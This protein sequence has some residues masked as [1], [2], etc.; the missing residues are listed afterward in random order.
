MPAK[1]FPA[2][3][4]VR[5]RTDESSNESD[6]RRSLSM[7]VLVFVELARQRDRLRFPMAFSMI[8]CA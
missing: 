3:T 5:S 8:N 2:C 1:P 6:I 4:A 7:A